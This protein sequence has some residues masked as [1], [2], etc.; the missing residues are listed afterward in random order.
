MDLDYAAVE[1]VAVAP[2]TPS[3][4]RAIAE[5]FK[6]LGDAAHSLAR[7]F[8]PS[9]PV[10]PPMKLKRKMKAEPGAPDKPKRAP[11]AYNMFVKEQMPLYLKEARGRPLPPARCR[12]VRRLRH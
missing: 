3:Q 9:V 12:G 5:Q 10:A 7:L 6:K 4:Q 1:P 8:D 2:A 11:T